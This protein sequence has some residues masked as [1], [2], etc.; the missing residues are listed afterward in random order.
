MLVVMFRLKLTIFEFHVGGLWVLRPLARDLALK[1]GSARPEV[2][3]CFGRPW[4]FRLLARM[5]T[6]V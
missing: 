4:R 1:S 3:H 6:S 2:A 5:I